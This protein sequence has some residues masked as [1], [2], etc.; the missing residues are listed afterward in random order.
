MRSVLGDNLRIMIGIR[1]PLPQGVT[2][3]ILDPTTA[4]K[5]RMANGGVG[6]E[7]TR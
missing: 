1:P 2:T 7:E 3:G 6:T 5:H 4:K